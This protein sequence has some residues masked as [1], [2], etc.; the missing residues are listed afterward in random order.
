[1]SFTSIPVLDLAL[2]K[3]PETK[4]AFLAELRYA[5][6]EVGFLYLKNVGIPDTLFQEVIR[7]GRAFF[8]IPIEEKYCKL[9]IS[10]VDAR[11]GGSWTNV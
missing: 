7:E 8:D 11:S 2:S 5:L 4:P 6:M 10:G 9:V 3:D 1:M